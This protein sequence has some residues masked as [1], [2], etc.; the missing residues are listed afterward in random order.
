MEEKQTGVRKTVLLDEDLVQQ[1][2]QLYGAAGV[3]NFSQFV[4]QALT[5]YTQILVME[6]YQDLLSKEVR[7][8]LA[9][10]L[11]PIKTRLSKSLYRYAVE[12]DMLCQILGYYIGDYSEVNMEYIRRAA[13]VRVAKT[14]GFLD[15]GKLLKEE[16]NDDDYGD[17]W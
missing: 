6:N 2:E 17:D 15:V 7:K 14:R 16:V 13:N 3:K 8:G 10:E 11:E 1:C 5:Q 12:L 4:K 9:K